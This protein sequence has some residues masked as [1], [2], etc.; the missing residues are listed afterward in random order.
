MYVNVL[1]N[2]KGTFNYGMIHN[3]VE[4]VTC[5]LTAKEDVGDFFSNILLE[6]IDQSLF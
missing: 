5:I 2:T 1:G 6:H 3:I 4:A